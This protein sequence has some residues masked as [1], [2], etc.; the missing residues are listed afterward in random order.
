MLGS[1]D[2]A[3]ASAPPGS[4]QPRLFGDSGDIPRQIGAP[5]G[6]GSG[7]KLSSLSLVFFSHHLGCDKMQTQLPSDWGKPI[8]HRAWAQAAPKAELRLCCPH[9]TGVG[10]GWQSQGTGIVFGS[11]NDTGAAGSSAGDGNFCSQEGGGC[12]CQNT[13]SPGQEGLP[14]GTSFPLFQSF[15]SPLPA[16]EPG[17]TLVQQGQTQLSP[18]LR[19]G[20]VLLRGHWGGYRHRNDP[21]SCCLWVLAA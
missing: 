15:P 17:T 3:G 8:A 20:W 21:T 18:Q 9:S 2:D 14:R 4:L 13:E 12:A 5:R 7:H 19:E 11:G 1:Q 16:A 10:M 6:G